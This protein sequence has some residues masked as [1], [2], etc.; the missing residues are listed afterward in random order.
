MRRH[1]AGTHDL[2]MALPWMASDQHGDEIAA[3]LLHMVA[4]CY[5][6]WREDASV[7]AEAFARWRTAPRDERSRRFA[8][9]GAALDQE[10]TAAETYATALSDCELWLEW[11]ATR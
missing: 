8:A 2:A 11:P 6:S 4:E 3:P 1:P 5:L 10:A 9:Y 7:V